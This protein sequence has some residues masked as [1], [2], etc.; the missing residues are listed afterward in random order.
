MKMLRASGGHGWEPR[1]EQ[2]GRSGRSGSSFADETVQFPFVTIGKVSFF[3][4]PRL[5]FLADFAGCQDLFLE[6]P[7]LGVPSR[8]PSRRG[9]RRSWRR[10][11]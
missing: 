2:F 6:G 7:A 9:D 11:A 1:L 8:A 3:F 10:G 4:S 5:I